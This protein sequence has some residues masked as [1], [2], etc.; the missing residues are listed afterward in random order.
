MKQRGELRSEAERGRRHGRGLLYVMRQ[1]A[2]NLEVAEDIVQEAWRVL[3]E[4]FRAQ[5]STALD[6]PE[7][8]PAYIQHTAI[9]LFLAQ[10]RK[11][12]RRRTDTDSALLDEVVDENGGDALDEL[13]RQHLCQSVR[14]CIAALDNERDRKLLYWYYI[15][16]RS[17]Q[18]ICDELALESRHFD[19]V[20]HRARNRFRLRLR[21]G[22]PWPTAR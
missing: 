22:E 13:M 14:D 18:S 10:E 16:E 8:L 11:H 9:K 4:K 5:G 17:K 19:R 15:E 7:R 21:E 3:L 2:G 20:A 1:R 6:D 12:Q